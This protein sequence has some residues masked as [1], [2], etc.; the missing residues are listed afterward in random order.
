[1]QTKSASRAILLLTGSVDSLL[2]GKLMQLQGID[3]V[4]YCWSLPFSHGSQHAEAAANQLQIPFHVLEADEAYL[5]NVVSM[6]RFGRG[7]GIAPC[8][9]CRVWLYRA[10]AKVLH[11][12]SASFIITGEV[13]G[14]RTATQRKSDF[15][16][17]EYHA[18]LSGKVVRPLSGRLLPVTI[19]EQEE[20]IT[21]DHFQSFYGTSR[22]PQ[23]NLA[24]QLGLS[25][26][27]ASTY[28]SQ[29]RLTGNPTAQ[30][31]RHLLQ[32]QS[33]LTPLLA[34][35]SQLGRHFTSAAGSQIIL[36]RNQE[37]NQRLERAYH[38]L[39]K[40]PNRLLQADNS[41]GPLAFIFDE[42]DVTAIQEAKDRL[43]Q[44]SK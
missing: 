32:I 42:S 9:D 41:G 27:F 13:V 34:E 26:D 24:E 35:L 25:T 1:M 6:P 39:G 20:V 17:L 7:K 21:R 18:G 23:I 40:P 15:E 30:R 11:E 5:Q 19:A 33:P 2:A 38:R 14:Q 43:H 44:Y 22:A 10:A 28:A 12:S 4:A 3:L 36:G 37:E 29:C 31:V 16:M 8:T